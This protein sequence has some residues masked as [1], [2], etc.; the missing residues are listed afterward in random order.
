M[1]DEDLLKNCK[2]TS[3]LPDKSMIDG[4]ELL[5]PMYFFVISIPS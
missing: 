5:S 2:N 4:F 1:F 3:K